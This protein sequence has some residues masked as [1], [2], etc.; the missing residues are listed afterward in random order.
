MIARGKALAVQGMWYSG[1][2]LL[3]DVLSCHKELTAI[4]GHLD[5]FRK[6]GGILDLVQGLD[7]DPN[8]VPTFSRAH[9]FKW[10]AARLGLHGR[11]KSGRQYLRRERLLADFQERLSLIQD[12][13]MR[14]DVAQEWWNELKALY[15]IKENGA[16]IDVPVSWSQFWPSNLSLLQISKTFVVVRDPDD[17]VAG[18]ARRQLY[19][20]LRGI[21]SYDHERNRVQAI[22][23]VCNRIQVFYEYLLAALGSFSPGEIAIVKFEKL[24]EHPEKTIGFLDDVLET[25]GFQSESSRLSGILG[26]S[27]VNVGIGKDLNVRSEIPNREKLQELHREVME[28]SHY[29]AP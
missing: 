12:F 22:N 21:Q 23:H 4:P 24:G 13:E 7:S 9:S 2:S 27:R 20:H 11:S 14:K 17:H 8:Y 26:M 18:V 6:P 29:L 1:S 16:L 10:K 25:R 5:D 28:S 15:G 19:F 3:V